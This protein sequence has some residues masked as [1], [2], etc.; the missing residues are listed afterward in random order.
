MLWFYGLLG[1]QPRHWPGMCRSA[2]L[3]HAVCC[4]SVTNYFVS[5]PVRRRVYRS[6]CW[7]WRVRS[8]FP[9]LL[10]PATP[11]F[12]QMVWS[13]GVRLQ[14]FECDPAPIQHDGVPSKCFGVDKH[15]PFSAMVM[16]GDHA[17]G[18]KINPKDKRSWPTK[19]K[20]AAATSQLASHELRA[21]AVG[22][23]K[24]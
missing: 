2:V 11:S 10:T 23:F 3:T 18:V 19:A 15:F 13:R 24:N 22:Y 20:G 12:D 8:T 9:L 17:T 16:H 21:S 6:S 7:A 5:G 1:S 4:R 14:A